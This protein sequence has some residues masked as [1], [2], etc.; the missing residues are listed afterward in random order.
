MSPTLAKLRTPVARLAPRQSLA[1]C[2]MAAGEAQHVTADARLVRSVGPADGCS[3]RSIAAI[4]AVPVGVLA[5]FDLGA[6]FK[7]GLVLGGHLL[8]VAAGKVGDP[9][10]KGH[11][12]SVVRA[13]GIDEGG[14]GWRG[15]LGTGLL[16]RNAPLNL[17][18]R[19]RRM[20]EFVQG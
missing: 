2:R 18:T 19:S 1:A 6:L 8:N 7:R 17:V 20:S 5:G 16:G 15:T 10:D 3:W 14:P 4:I 12:G 9:F 13:A 11:E